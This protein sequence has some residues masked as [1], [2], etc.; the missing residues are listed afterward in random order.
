[1]HNTLLRLLRWAGR[2][3]LMMYRQYRAEQVLAMM[4]QAGFADVELQVFMLEEQDGFHPYFLG[5]KS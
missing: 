4:R 1:M 3:H 5:R 2:R